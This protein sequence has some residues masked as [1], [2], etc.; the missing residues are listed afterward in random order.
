[1]KFKIGILIQ[2]LYGSL[3][4]FWMHIVGARQMLGINMYVQS[5]G[6]VVAVA[7]GGG[8]NLSLTPNPD[9]SGLFGS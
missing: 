4:C 8:G 2:V 7:R 1:M 3:F 9:K 6:C 5:E